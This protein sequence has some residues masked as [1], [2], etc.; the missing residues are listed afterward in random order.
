MRDIPLQIWNAYIISDYHKRGIQY[1]PNK[2]QFDFTDGAKS[3]IIL[4]N[5]RLDDD[6]NF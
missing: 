1:T 5:G 6:I 4:P 2:K 3:T